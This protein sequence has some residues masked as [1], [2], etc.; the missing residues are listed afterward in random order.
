MD[1][2][3]QEQ[4][5][6]ERDLFVDAEADT[7]KSE[8][9]GK[10]EESSTEQK[11]DEQ[12]EEN[13]EDL[14][15]NESEEVIVDDS[16]KEIAQPEEKVEI[17][18]VSGET[19]RE[20]ALRLEVTKLRNQLRE[21]TTITPAEKTDLDAN[22]IKKGYD[23][24]EIKKVKELLTDLGVVTKDEVQKSEKNKAIASFVAKHPEYAPQNDRDDVL[25]KA[26]LTEFHGGF[27]NNTSDDPVV[28]TKIL[29]D[30]HAKLSDTKSKP[31]NQ[32]AIAA[33]QAKI[34]SAGVGGSGV[35]PP[36]S[37]KSKNIDPVVRQFL[38]GF[39]EDELAEI[40]DK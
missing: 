33:Q 14:V 23:P 7:T 29:E 39:T 32:S 18:D 37:N 5:V 31:V 17:K 19:P 20:K 24:N 25:W 38:K 10:P 2:K 15:K 6:K 13:K 3:E 27:Y 11:P 28:V 30:I 36:S 16:Q 9:E 26:V 21:K 4:E 22:L 12:S 40:S 35:Q 34:K 1:N 8:Q